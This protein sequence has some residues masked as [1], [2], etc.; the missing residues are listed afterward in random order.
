MTVG[1]L[2]LG[3]GVVGL[4]L[5]LGAGRGPA[6]PSVAAH[7]TIFPGVPQSGHSLGREDAPV[8][9]DVY[10]DFQCPACLNWTATVLPGLVQTEVAAG[11]V[12][13]VAH[14]NAFIGPESI[15]AGRA[16]WAAE[17]QGRFWDYD[18]GLYRM[19]GAENS[20]VYTDASLMAL[21]E[22]LGLDVERF[23]RDYTSGDSLRAVQDARNDAQQRGISSTPTVL[24][25]G[26]RQANASLDS[27][28]S[29]IA[30]LVS[31]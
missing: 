14:D 12:R 16:A 21:A 20:G 15:L 27:L 4:A 18:V 19:Q 23:R 30:A 10:E 25:N 5:V 8:T 3:L 6:L 11:R 28:R 26:Q 1:A 13:I 29:A 7:S 24:L 31:G 9:L 2:V 17:R 22:S